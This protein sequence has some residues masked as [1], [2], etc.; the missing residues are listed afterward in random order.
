M[1]P[2][3]FEPTIIVMEGSKTVRASDRATVVVGNLWVYT[4]LP[5]KIIIALQPFVWVL[6]ALVSWSYT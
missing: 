5:L 3:G 2:V 6:A 4:V 1:P